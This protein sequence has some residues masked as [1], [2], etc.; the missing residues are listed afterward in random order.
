MTAYNHRRA[1]AE[2]GDYWVA[3]HTWVFDQGLSHVALCT[4]IALAS[5]ADR[6]GKA[7]PSTAAIADRIALSRKSV[8]RGLTELEEAGLVKRAA[9]FKN[10]ARQPSVYWVRLIAPPERALEPDVE[11]M[12]ADGSTGFV[13]ADPGLGL[14]DPGLGLTDPGL[15]L[16]DPGLGLTDPQNTSIEHLH[17]TPTESPSVDGHLGLVRQRAEARPTTT[18]DAK[19]KRRGTRIPNDFAVTSEMATWATQNV[20]LVDVVAETDRF[21]DYW[22]AVSGQ[23]G[24]KLDWVATWRNWMRRADDDRTRGRRSQAQIMRDNAA[25]AIANDQ[26]TALPA[27]DALAGFL[28]GGQPSWG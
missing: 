25:A 19:P 22:T 21:R 28:E 7:W 24:T 6:A 8:Q 23:R 17:R 1:P 9:Q 11:V 15:G 5:F 10:G 13:E 4:Y 27:P 12:L 16:T 26:R 20:P 14:T 3:I 2:R 18:D